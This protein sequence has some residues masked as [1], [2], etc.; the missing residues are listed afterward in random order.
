MPR[1]VGWPKAV[2]L[3]FQYVFWVKGVVLIQTIYVSELTHL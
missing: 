2:Y 1:L 3:L